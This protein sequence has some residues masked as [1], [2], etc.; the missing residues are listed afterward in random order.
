MSY[1]FLF[2]VCHAASV[3]GQFPLYSFAPQEPT[4]MS[5]YQRSILA[6]YEPITE[7]CTLLSQPYH[8]QEHFSFTFPKIMLHGTQMTLLPLR[9]NIYKLLCDTLWSK[10]PHWSIDA[11]HKVALVKFHCEKKHRHFSAVKLI[12]F[13]RVNLKCP[14]CTYG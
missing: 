5:S 2:R 11:P 3:I 12:I 4:K 7:F 10:A 1:N 6:G 9:V 14:K 13:G 8:Y